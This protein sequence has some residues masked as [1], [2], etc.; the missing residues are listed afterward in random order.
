MY[1][2]VIQ[3]TNGL[4]CIDAMGR[5]LSIAGNNHIVPGMAVWTDGNIV[6]GN[7]YSGGGTYIPVITGAE[8]YLWLETGPDGRQR[9]L[10]ID[11]KTEKA[12]ELMKT[13]G[14][15][16]EWIVSDN[17]ICYVR[18]GGNVYNLVSGECLGREPEYCDDYN[19]GND[20]SLLGVRGG[21]YS[22]G[23]SHYY[24][25]THP[26]SS[27]DHE[28]GFLEFVHDTE[29]ASYTRRY[30]VSSSN[31]DN[32]MTVY[33]NLEKA[34]TVSA[35]GYALPMDGLDCVSGAGTFNDGVHGYSYGGISDVFV[36]KDMGTYYMY[37]GGSYAIGDLWITSPQLKSQPFFRAFV[38]NGSRGMSGTTYDGQIYSSHYVN[39]SNLG[40][41]NGIWYHHS[42][43]SGM[44]PK[45]TSIKREGYDFQWSDT[46]R[47]N[48]APLGEDAEA[49]VKRGESD[50]YEEHEEKGGYYTAK[51]NGAAV[52]EPRRYMMKPI[53]PGTNPVLWVS[54]PNA[55]V[56][57]VKYTHKESVR[58]KIVDEVKEWYGMCYIFHTVNGS[59]KWDTTEYEYYHPWF[60]VL[61]TNSKSRKDLSDMPVGC[62]VTSL[63]VD[64]T[65]GD[66]SVYHRDLGNYV[67]AYNNYQCSVPA[68]GWSYGYWDYDVFSISDARSG[69]HFI[70]CYDWMAHCYALYYRNGGMK[71]LC[72]SMYKDNF[73]IGYFKAASVRRIRQNLNAILGGK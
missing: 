39:A 18:I 3:S 55:Y 40:H 31:G 17:D 47:L 19:I 59:E 8:G 63:I 20:G 10:L 14:R 64:E 56:T 72:A 11:S 28:P 33:R 7:M 22:S 16:I 32:L 37:S 15:T 65:A 24:E 69:G 70:I 58:I 12:T 50:T 36:H 61:G 67:I 2:T 46:S 30:S 53:I 21:S 44:E 9:L 1:Q 45:Q 62:Y 71:S 5:T 66:S 41:D 73:H 42:W 26:R 60:I 48:Y 35:A 68:L 43:D 25:E 6:Y 57:K 54:S 34:G 52:A 27:Y 29:A 4:S 51:I 23:G 49:F 38:L 13:S